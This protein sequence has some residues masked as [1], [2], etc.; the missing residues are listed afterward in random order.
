MGYTRPIVEQM[1]KQN[2]P[3]QFFYLAMQ[4]SDFELFRGGRRRWGIAK[5]CG[6][7]S[8]TGARYGLRIGPPQGAGSDKDDEQLHWERYAAAAYRDI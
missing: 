6:S 2:L 4:E 7:S 5:G 1:L 3:P 8:D